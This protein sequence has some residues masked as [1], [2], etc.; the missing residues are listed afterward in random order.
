ML[1]DTTFNNVLVN[2]EM[3]VHVNECFKRIVDLTEPLP[4]HLNISGYAPDYYCK[5]CAVS[6][7]LQKIVH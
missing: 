5:Y 3:N 2:F 1:T 4:T 6:P 7:F